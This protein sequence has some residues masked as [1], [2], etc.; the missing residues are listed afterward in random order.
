MFKA[1]L[2]LWVASAA[3]AEDLLPLQFIRKV[4]TAVYELPELAGRTE[5]LGAVEGGVRLPEVLSAPGDY[6]LHWQPC[7]QLPSTTR[8][9]CAEPAESALAVNFLLA[10]RHDVA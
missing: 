6:P 5:M 8:W 7:E 9:G 1:T 10:S 3:M 4:H 2:M